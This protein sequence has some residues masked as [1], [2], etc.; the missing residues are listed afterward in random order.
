MRARRPVILGLLAILALAWASPSWGQMGYNPPRGPISPWMNMFQRRVGPLD[1][2]NSWVRPQIQL[3]DAMARQN[4]AIQQQAAGLEALGQ[5]V[6]VKPGAHQPIRPTGTGS[7]F[8]NFGHYYP[9]LGG[10]P[11]NRVQPSPRPSLS[12]VRGGA[13]FGR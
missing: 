12:A 3:Q 13:R 9:M 1:N 4:F 10:S 8:M 2:Y 11:L 6:E 7:V 5:Q